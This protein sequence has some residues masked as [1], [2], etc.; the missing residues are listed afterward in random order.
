MLNR[1]LNIPGF[2]RCVPEKK[3]KL[4]SNAIYCLFCFNVL[5]IDFMHFF[6][7]FYL[8]MTS[9]C[10]SVQLY[11]ILHIYELFFYIYNIYYCVKNSTQIFLYHVYTLVIRKYKIS[12]I[13]STQQ[14]I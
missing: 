9:I 7:P 6:I 14:E 8:D 4:L 3:K 10:C 2:S 12:L 13:S 5:C 1:A 11:R